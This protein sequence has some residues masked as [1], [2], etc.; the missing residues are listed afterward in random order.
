MCHME[1]TAGQSKPLLCLTATHPQGL[2]GW[3]GR[4][5]TRRRGEGW[6]ERLTRD[7]RCLLPRPARTSSPRTAAC[8]AGAPSYRLRHKGRAGLRAAWA[9]PRRPSPC[10]PGA[11]AAGLGPGSAWLIPATASSVTGLLEACERVSFGLTEACPLDGVASVGTSVPPPL[12][13]SPKAF[14]GACGPFPSHCH[15]QPLSQRSPLHP[16]LTV[17]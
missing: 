3:G 14:G 15:I 6:G 12:V 1:G 11:P 7:G 4:S 2:G 5:G 10:T 13:L 17:G 8:R 16:P 9:G